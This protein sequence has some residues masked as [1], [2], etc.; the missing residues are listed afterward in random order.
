M[1]GIEPDTIAIV[2]DDHAAREALEFLL[3][4]LGR[5]PEGFASAA[6]FL[7]SEWD[8]FACLILDHHMPVMTGVEL[9][10]QLRAGE[11]KI[12]ILLISG[13]LTSDVAQKAAN[14]GIDM[15]A[16]KPVDLATL[17]AF[18]GKWTG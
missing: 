6:D 7:K 17:S 10:R 1:S 13:D 15:V 12:P 5:R 8:R 3:N 2:D 18:L 4:V 9:A 16:D 11:S 14:I